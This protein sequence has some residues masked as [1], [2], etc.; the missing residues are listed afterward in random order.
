MSRS[1]KKKSR[2]C[3]GNLRKS[4]K[5]G[6]ALLGRKMCNYN[7]ARTIASAAECK[8][9]YKLPFSTENKLLSEVD[10]CNNLI[11]QIGSQYYYCRNGENK[12]GLCRDRSNTGAGICSN[13]K[14]AQLLQQFQINKTAPKSTLTRKN[15]TTQSKIKPSV[16]YRDYKKW[17]ASSGVRTFSQ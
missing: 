11:Y 2:R 9:Y 13:S 8:N 10:D 5:G 7:T 16:T 3:Q 14:N 1:R 12:R 6:L 15:V 17:K 4:R